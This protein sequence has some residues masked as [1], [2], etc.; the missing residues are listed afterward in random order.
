MQYFVSLAQFFQ[1]ILTFASGVI[2]INIFGQTVELNEYFSIFSVYMLFAGIIAAPF[3]QSF[4]KFIKDSNNNILV[5]RAIKMII[6]FSLLSIFL[7]VAMM[8]LLES[9]LNL[10]SD[11]FKGEGYILVICIF[12]STLFFNLLSAILS[13][14]LVARRKLLT[15][16]IYS[17]LLPIIL[18]I[19]CLKYRNEIGILVVVYAYGIG[20]FAVLLGLL[21]NTKALLFTTTSYNLQ[22]PIELE[23][24][25]IYFIKGCIGILPLVSLGPIFT[26]IASSDIS[27]N[28]AYFTIGISFAGVI[29]ILS[30]YGQFLTKISSD[31]KLDTVGSIRTIIIVLLIASLFALIT[32]LAFSAFSSMIYDIPFDE[33]KFKIFNSIV[34]SSIFISGYNI[35]RADDWT[36]AYKIKNLALS[37][38]LIFVS[39]IVL[40]YVKNSFGAGILLSSVYS[41]IYLALLNLRMIS[42]YDG[43][44]N[45]SKAIAV[46]FCIYILFNYFFV[47]I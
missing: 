11:V 38:L 20:A 12:A 4:A 45:C 13:S 27:I 42:I 10:S 1:S 29:S 16:I 47:Y 37:V 22:S 40:Y 9:S 33:N 18:A 7:W 31:T 6:I 5:L 43:M 14:I 30:S 19:L 39:F 8:Y 23:P 41:F 28:I 34:I 25:Y 46:S 15:P 21:V 2:I 26:F 24:F 3:M 36:I 17:Y 35:V 32:I 44:A